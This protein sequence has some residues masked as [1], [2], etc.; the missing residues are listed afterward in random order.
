MGSGPPA[1]WTPAVKKGQKSMKAMGLVISVMLV[2]ELSQWIHMHMYGRFLSYGCLRFVSSST[3]V[4]YHIS[5][6]FLYIHS[7]PRPPPPKA[8]PKK[9]KGKKKKKKVKKVKKDKKTKP[10]KKKQKDEKKEVKKKQKDEK[11]QKDDT[12]PPKKLKRGST[13]YNNTWG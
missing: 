7:C 6:L 8:T 12:P 10:T 4:L 1:K 9:E 5:I 3:S 11:K 13:G 2:L